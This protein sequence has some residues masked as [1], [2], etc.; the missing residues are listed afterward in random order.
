V[1]QLGEDTF[2]DPMGVAR[3]R[4]GGFAGARH[5]DGGDSEPTDEREGE[6]QAVELN[7]QRVHTSGQTDQRQVRVR[8]GR[9]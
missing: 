1:V 5:V 9:E 6:G 7:L 3:Q 2:V 8:A 4:D